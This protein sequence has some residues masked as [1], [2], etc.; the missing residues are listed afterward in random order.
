LIGHRVSP[1]PW[2]EID[3]HGFAVQFVVDLIVVN[4]SCSLATC[5]TTRGTKMYSKRSF[6]LYACTVDDVDLSSALAAE[7]IIVINRIQ[8]FILSGGRCCCHDAY[9][10][11]KNVRAFVVVAPCS[12]CL[13][14]RCLR[15]LTSAVT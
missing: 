14:L 7:N 4:L 10:L 2:R 6:R 13:L 1:Q 9:R 8:Y 15:L 3:A 11:L 12:N 5:C